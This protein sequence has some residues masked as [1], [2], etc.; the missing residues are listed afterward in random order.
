MS[1]CY[2][3]E[4]EKIDLE[5]EENIR[6]YAIGDQSTATILN[7]AGKVKIYTKPV[8]NIYNFPTVSEDLITLETQRRKIMKSLH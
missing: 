5:L 4:G 7:N 3:G 8:R 6:E 2:F 1:Y